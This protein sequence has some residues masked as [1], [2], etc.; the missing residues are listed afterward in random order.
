MG[1][2]LTDNQCL[3]PSKPIKWPSNHTPVV[4]SLPDVDNNSITVSSPSDTEPLTEATS[5]SSR[6]PGVLHGVITVTLE[7]EPPTTPA[8]SSMLLPTQKL[9]L[10]TEVYIIKS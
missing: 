6:T 2:P 4:S 1:P 8:V 3:L 5:S 9:E 10:L 7:S